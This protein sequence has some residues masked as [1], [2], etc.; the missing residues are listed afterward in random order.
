MRFVPLGI[1]PTCTGNTQSGRLTS[2]FKWDHPRTCGEHSTVTISPLLSAGSSPHVRGAQFRGEFVDHLVGIIPACA[3]STKCQCGRISFIGDHPRMCGEH[4]QCPPK[5]AWSSGSSP[6]V[7]GAPIRR[8]FSRWTK[9]IIP[10]CAGSTDASSRSTA[11]SRDHPR[12]C[13]EH[14]DAEF[15]LASTSGSSPHVRGARCPHLHAIV[16]SGIIPACAG[17]TTSGRGGR[18]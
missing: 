3:G 6:H 14:L 18:G 11:T 15:M 5:P 10:A 12:M 4:W 16:E 1:I 13:G 8:W 17:S 2:K 9:G 7:R